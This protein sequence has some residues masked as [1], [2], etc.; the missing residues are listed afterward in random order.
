MLVTLP[1]AH[2]EAVVELQQPAFV[3]KHAM[4]V[5]IVAVTLPSYAMKVR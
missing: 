2:M 3:M 4:S 5:L 1:V